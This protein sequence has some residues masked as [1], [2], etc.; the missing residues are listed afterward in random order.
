M[1]QFQQNDPFKDLKDGVHN[2]ADRTSEFN[3]EDIRR[4]KGVSSLAY[5]PLL[6]W[7]PLVARSNSR[8]AKFHANQGLIFFIVMAVLDIVERF[9]TFIPYLHSLI[10]ACVSLIGLCYFL[11][12]FINT[13]NGNA[14]ELPFIGKFD[15][16]KY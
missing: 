12:G 14:R 6:F 11:Y 10:S 2:T 4:N 5:I 15:L 13:L 7:I 9:F 16:I 8:F 1:P 3:V